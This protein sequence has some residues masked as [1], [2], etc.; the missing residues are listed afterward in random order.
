MSTSTRHNRKAAWIFSMAASIAVFASTLHAD[1]AKRKNPTSKLYVADVEGLASIN[2]GDKIEDLNKRSVYTAEG[3]VL[4]TT[5]KSSNSIVLSNGTG[6]SIDPDTRLEISRFLQEPFS[7]NRT[8]LEVEPS[9][10]QTS[11][12]LPRGTVGLCTSKLIA[13][14][15]MTYSTR[16]GSVAIRGRKVVI[17]A[18]DDKTIISLLEG[19][20]TVMGDML[21]GGQNLK[22]GQ[23][24]IITRKSNTEPPVITIQPIPEADRSR[25]GDKVALACLAR[26][27]VYFETAERK[28]QSSSDGVFGQNDADGNP[29]ITAVPVLPG[30][31]QPPTP[32]SPYKVTP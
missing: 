18:K 4:E 24:A 20:V 11:V 27:T 26:K 28:N 29:V 1:D 15:T 5:P 22:P 21:A 32:I 25:L 7:P 9:I 3:V 23:Q 6:L 30:T 13:G 17:E 2:T 31:L 8:D 16:Q 10:S 19:D 12:F 14:S